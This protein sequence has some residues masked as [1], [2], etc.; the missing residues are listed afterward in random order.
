MGEDAAKD[1]FC[2]M[3][4]A[5]LK[6]APTN[7]KV[8]IL[9]DFNAELGNAWQEQGSVTGKFH[10]HRGAAD[11]LTMVPACLT[12]LNFFTFERPTPSL[13]TAWAIWQHGSKPPPITS[14]SKT[15]FWSL[16]MLC[17]G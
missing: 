6:E 15:T 7:D 14:T 12:W 2:L 4:F 3:L 10:L 13:N 16:A 5:Y 1:A 17:G 8:V 11:H 9:G